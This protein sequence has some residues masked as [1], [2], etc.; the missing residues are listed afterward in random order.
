MGDVTE[1]FPKHIDACP[2]DVIERVRERVQD[3]DDLLV[4]A[5]WKNGT[6]HYW[7]SDIEV[8]D[9]IAM[10]ENTKLQLAM[11]YMVRRQEDE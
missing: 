10:L 6:M 7:V 3:A 9:A 8:G 11:D 1:L 5:K 2:E 4:I